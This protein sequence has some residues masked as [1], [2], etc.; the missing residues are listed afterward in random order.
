MNE[1]RCVYGV[2]QEGE[3]ERE[4][5]TKDYRKTD[6]HSFVYMLPSLRSFLLSLLVVGSL[7]EQIER[8]AKL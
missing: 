3:R 6:I 2:E 1:I 7:Y 5:K 4:R 8:H